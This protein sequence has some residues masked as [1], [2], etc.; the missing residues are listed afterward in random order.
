[1]ASSLKDQKS[2]KLAGRPRARLVRSHMAAQFGRKLLHFLEVKKSAIS[3]LLIVT[4]DYPDPDAL[5]AAMALQYLGASLR[6]QIQDRLQGEH[7]PRREPGHGESP[8]SS[9]P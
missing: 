6:D 3:P 2:V 5:A 9:H 7:R 1:M 4:H 8:Q